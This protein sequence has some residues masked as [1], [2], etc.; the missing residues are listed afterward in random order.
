MVVIKLSFTTVTDDG[1]VSIHLYDLPENVQIEIIDS[2]ELEG[3]DEFIV[4][5][6]RFV[7]FNKEHHSKILDHIFGPYIDNVIMVNTER[8]LTSKL[9]TPDLYLESLSL[10]DLIFVCGLFHGLN[11][12]KYL[13]PL[14]SIVKEKHKIGFNQLKEL[15]KASK[16]KMVVYAK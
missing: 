8:G 2:L 13:I 7:D 10:D 14:I 16:F 9:S 3:F 5:F 6:P 12:K 4:S 11:F 15:A 1:D